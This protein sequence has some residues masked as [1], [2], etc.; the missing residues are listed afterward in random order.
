[1][2]IIVAK[3]AGY[4]FGVQ[5]AIETVEDSIQKYNKSIYTLGPI[6]HNNQVIEN[7]EKQ[8]VYSINN[9][10]EIED[11][12]TI[13]RSH[14][15]EPKVYETVEKKKLDVVDATCPYV[16]N[17][18]DKVRKYYNQGYQIVIV[19]NQDHPEVIGV[20]GW[21]DNTA[22]ILN[23]IEEVK[24]VSYY[25]KICVVAQTTIIESI[26]SEII[27]KIVPK[28]KEIVIFNTICNTTVKRQ[29]EAK[30][31]SQIV[32]VMIVIG[33]YHSSNTQKLANIC[34]K[35]CNN[36]YHIETYEDLPL[37][38]M[39][40]YNKIGITAGASTPDWIIKEV[41]EK[42]ENQINNNTENQQKDFKES[43]EESLVKIQKNDIVTGEVISVNASEIVVNIGYKADAVIS[44]NELTDKDVALNDIIQVGDKI[45]VMI[46][47]LN[48]GEGN[49]IASKQRV[50]RKKATEKIKGAFENEEMLDGTITKSVKGGFMVN[51]GFMDV[52][53]P[54]SQ[55]HIEYIKDPESV[56][57]KNV[58]GKIIE[59]DPSKNRIIY[60]QRIV[61]EKEIKDKKEKVLDSLK[62]GQTIT[63]AVKNIVK[64][65]AFIDLG[66][67]DGLIH[68]SD[69]SW[70]RV[71][72]PQDVLSIGETVTAKVI[73]VDRENEKVKL[74]LKALEEE[75][76][77]KVF[78]VYSVGDKINVKVTKLM[79]FGAFAEII[80]GVEGLIHKSQISYEPIEKVEDILQQGQEVETQII[81]MNKEKKRIGL[82]IIAL[83]DKPT[84]KIEKDETVYQEKDDLT[85]G[86]VFGNLFN[87]K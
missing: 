50:D 22:I 62:E 3:S 10:D 71:Q 25:K 13:I 53:M 27:S 1:M 2:E 69:L 42:M 79:N 85:L 64:F 21:C 34:K 5:K 37:S 65:G 17:I 8:G 87:E 51:I 36:T 14:G 76:W 4:C 23:S 86:D 78:R 77:S 30:E 11:G 63:G 81:D 82:S 57:G 24:E 7:L 31:L 45:E 60:S 80:P 39:I 72:K 56:V 74:S 68:I 75:P 48:D 54:L 35:Y 16:R 41:I 19:G 18:Q 52:F 32:D 55:Y 38:E 12:V 83:Q 70:Q 26:F 44:K 67:I 15:V 61:L 20:N 28:S 84:K 33:G 49:V 40:R 46:L 29:E 6:I 9:I 66:G 59:Y 73:E 58:R 43:V 47:S